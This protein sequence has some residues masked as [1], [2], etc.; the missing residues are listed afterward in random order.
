[1]SNVPVPLEQR[2]LD[3][4]SFIEA[5]AKAT[6]GEWKTRGD[7]YVYSDAIMVADNNDD[8]AILRA[9]GVGGGMSKEQQRNNIRFVVLAANQAARIAED[10][11]VA[12]EGYQKFYDVWFEHGCESYSK[13]CPICAA[14]DIIQSREFI[15]KLTQ[16]TVQG[17]E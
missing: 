10:L 12:I 5:R 4:K 6:Q 7:I 16:P 3:L 9:R 15:D 8:S 2:K 11:I 1:M 14:E 17:G 13:P